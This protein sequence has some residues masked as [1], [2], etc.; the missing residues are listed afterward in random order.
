MF[1]ASNGIRINVKEQ[2]KG[3][4]TLVFL[5][6]WG[7]SSR[8]WDDVIAALPAKYQT[9]APDLRGWGDS[10]APDSGYA[11][12]DFAND[13]AEV[14]AALDIQNYILI[15]HSMG[16]KIAQLFASRQPRGLVGLVLV[17]PSPPVP[18]TLPDEIRAQMFGAY[19]SRESVGMSIDHMLSGK[20]LST[21]HRE[22][23]IE[24]SLRGAPQAKNAW[25]AY[26]SREDITKD[27]AAISV[28]TI[29]IAGQ[30]DSVDSVE[31]LKEE[32]L[33]R[34]PQTVLHVVPET[35]HL[36][37]LESPNELAKLIHEF[38]SALPT[39]TRLPK[40]LEQF[41]VAFDTSFNAADV[42]AILECFTEDAAMRMTDGAVFNGRETMREY[43]AGMLQTPMHIRNEVR[44]AIPSGDFAL[45]L[46]DWTLTVTLPNGEKHVEKGTATQV[47]QRG[48]D[49]VWRLR[50]SNPLGLV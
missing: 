11:L 6:Y 21:A 37:P 25:P 35:G 49:G 42:G 1:I 45:L 2:G 14:I 30:I 24:D 32:V 40:T 41:P 38:A 5:H 50:V 19:E 17:A 31:L 10:E 4:P 34:I 48:T 15:G 3:S 22:Q 12:A 20:T 33:S 47:M 28:P 36:S 29:L 9:V 23:V 27:V 26:T 18:L 13:A 16:G 43:F 44:R 8:T 46:L 39:D 7:G